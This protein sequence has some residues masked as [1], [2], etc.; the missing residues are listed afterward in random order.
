MRDKSVID[1]IDNYISVVFL[2]FYRGGGWT[3]YNQTPRANSVNFVNKHSKKLGTLICSTYAR[4]VR[5]RDADRPDHGPSGRS[6]QC[7]TL[8]IAN[9]IMSHANQR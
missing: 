1:S 9:E 8:V 3:R 5:P 2:C 4:T 7:S 6:I